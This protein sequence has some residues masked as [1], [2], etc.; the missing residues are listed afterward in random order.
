MVKLPAKRRILFNRCANVMGWSPFHANS[1][2]HFLFI[3][4]ASV[5]EVIGHSRQGQDCKGNPASR[6][7]E[8]M[9]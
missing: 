2:R 6:V 4:T 8:T 9:L 5:A 1:C 3:S 7:G